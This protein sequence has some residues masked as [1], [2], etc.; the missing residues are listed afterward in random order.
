MCSFTVQNDEGQTDWR[1]AGILDLFQKLLGSANEDAQSI[2][3]HT[4]QKH[5]TSLASGILQPPD[6]QISPVSLHAFLSLWKK[7]L[8]IPSATARFLEEGGNESLVLLQYVT[9]VKTTGYVRLETV[10]LLN[11]LVVCEME[12]RGDSSHSCKIADRVVRWIQTGMLSGAVCTDHRAGFGWTLAD[13]LS[14]HSSSADILFKR[15]LG[16][17]CLRTISFT[18][19]K[20]RSEG[21]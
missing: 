7:L 1:A 2:S 16:L 19:S 20:H 17:L 11:K 18:L 15:K 9:C 4:L 8:T 5:W 3:V 13:H 14:Q 21:K 12:C 6:S 10:R